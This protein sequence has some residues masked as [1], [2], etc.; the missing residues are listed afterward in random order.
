MN[1]GAP[2]HYL[3]MLLP[4]L[5]SDA[6]SLWDVIQAWLTPNV[7]VWPIVFN[8]PNRIWIAILIV[9]LAG[10]SESIAQSVVLFANRVRPARFVLSLFFNAALVVTGYFFWVLSIA[11]VAT[12]VFE[13]QVEWDL[14]VVGLSMSYVPLF[15]GFLG[16]IPYAGERIVQLLYVV[17]LVITVHM[18][19]VLLVMQWW[20]AVTCALFGFILIELFRSTLGKPLVKLGDW[21]MDLV[22]GANLQLNTSGVDNE[23][24]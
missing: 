20:Q 12:F 1:M 5:Q 16:L 4:L 15:L 11:L 23:K 13:R 18:L 7:S 19:E 22:A 3:S 14:L 21:L 8:A 17:A 2:E 9:A 24:H 10:F 6:V